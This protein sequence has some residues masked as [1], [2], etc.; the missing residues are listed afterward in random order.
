MTESPRTLRNDSNRWKML[1]HFRA[2]LM[3]YWL[4]HYTICKNA[5]CEQTALCVTL[6]L[7]STI[8]YIGDNMTPLCSAESH[9]LW[10]IWLD[11]KDT[12]SMHELLELKI[13]CLHWR[14]PFRYTSMRDGN[15]F[16]VSKTW[17][18]KLGNRAQILISAPSRTKSILHNP[19]EVLDPAHVSGVAQT[20]AAI[21]LKLNDV[22]LSLDF[23]L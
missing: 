10:C 21:L 19:W 23:L 4:H 16:F 8:N 15:Y 7:T 13:D 1:F 12:W 14:V 2:E 22:G 6:S 5:N 17:W 9:W 20:S 3:W 18:A 11:S